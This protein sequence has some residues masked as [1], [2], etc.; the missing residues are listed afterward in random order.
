MQI[1]RAG[2]HG[3]PDAGADPAASIGF[4]DLTGYD[5]STHPGTWTPKRIV[6][7]LNVWN[8]RP[9]LERTLP[10]W[11][12]HV[13]HIVAVDG[14][15]AG[16]DAK[17][18]DDGTCEMLREHGAAIVNAPGFD[19]HDKRTHYFSYCEE[20]DL[21]LIVDADE[22]FTELDLSD[23]PYFDVGWITYTAPIYMRPQSIPRLI[24]W[25]PNLNYQKRHHW[26]YQ[27]D[28]PVCTNQ[29]GAAGYVHRRIPGVTFH[30]DR[31][32]H[33]T[34]ARQ[35]AGNRHRAIQ[36]HLEKRAAPEKRVW[37]HEPLRIA[38]VAPFDPGAVCYRFHTALNV[39]TPHTSVLIT[40]TEEWTQVPRQFDYMDELAPRLAYAAD[41]V[42]FHVNYSGPVRP[43]KWTVI[44]HHGTEYRIQPEH[45]N[46]MDAERADLRLVSNLELLQYGE[47][48]EWLPNPMPVAEY[49]RLARNRP[50][51]EK[52][53]LKIAHSPTKR[54]NKGSD[55]FDRAVDRCNKMGLKIQRHYI[56]KASIKGSLEAKAR[57]H[58][59]FDSFWLGIQ[60]SGLEAASM[61]L[62]VIA[63]DAHVKAQYEDRLGYCPYTYA[64]DGD[65][66]VE[67]IERLATDHAFYEAEMRRVTAYTLE[68]HDQANVIAR[69]LDLLDEAVQWR[70]NMEMGTP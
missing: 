29:L 34:D 63:G 65:A 58:A 35:K 51:W 41:V 2:Q 10:T 8:D 13:D 31:G 38:N 55:A 44:H 68:Y 19:Q 47:N 28:R 37:G 30:N 48:L 50:A 5:L 24:R 57:C 64:P 53:T 45:F 62:P 21:L 18:S 69:Y 16:I 66:L 54:K 40:G 20:G 39:L 7:C 52:G 15:Y 17:L 43:R 46:E 67:Q 36:A 27:E 12:D 22:A 1:R 56:H 60:C 3:R 70:D 23:L 61:G 26:L 42:H 25:M 32:K 59:M 6:A 11:I 33:R 4:Y 49:R 14:A 9:S